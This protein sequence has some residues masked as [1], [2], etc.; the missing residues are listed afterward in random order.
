MYMNIGKIPLV[1]VV[2]MNISIS[3]CNNITEYKV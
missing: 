1:F 2:Q 3:I